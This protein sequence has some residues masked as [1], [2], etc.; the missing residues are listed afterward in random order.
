MKST[1]SS[2]RGTSMTPK[3]ES[4]FTA[5]SKLPLL[6]KSSRWEW[7]FSRQQP[8][9]G[10]MVD[11][12]LCRNSAPARW[13]VCSALFRT[14]GLFTAPSLWRKAHCSG[15]GRCCRPDAASRFLNDIFTPLPLCL[16]PTV[17]APVGLGLSMVYLSCVHF[18]LM[19]TNWTHVHLSQPPSWSISG[20]T[21]VPGCMARDSAM[22]SCR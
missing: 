21:N 7:T 3:F 4:N 1:G 6:L 15:K 5:A 22:E 20:P 19:P 9:W 8:R 10:R 17:A 2:P 13:W 18:S 16:I 11:L 14:S 12:E